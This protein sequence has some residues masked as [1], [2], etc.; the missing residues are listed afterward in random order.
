MFVPETIFRHSIRLKQTDIPCWTIQSQ[1][2]KLIWARPVVEFFMNLSHKAWFVS[3]NYKFDVLPSGFRV[4]RESSKFYLNNSIELYGITFL[5][6]SIVSYTLYHKQPKELNK[7]WIMAE[8]LL[9]I[10]GFVFFIC[11]LRWIKLIYIRVGY[12]FVSR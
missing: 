12:V 2:D 3:W 11:P 5:D 4:S 6:V 9:L 7:I 10:W 8:S 1:S